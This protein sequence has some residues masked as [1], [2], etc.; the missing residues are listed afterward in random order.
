M[1][2]HSENASNEIGCH[3]AESNEEQRFE[4]LDREDASVERQNCEFDRR[5]RDGVTNLV[6][7]EYLDKLSRAIFGIRKDIDVSTKP[8]IS[9]RDQDAYRL[10]IAQRAGY[11]DQQIIIP[12]TSMGQFP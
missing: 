4:L 12:V 5:N 10:D 7:I 9:H 11:R 2:Y 1:E 8:T 3:D 6:D